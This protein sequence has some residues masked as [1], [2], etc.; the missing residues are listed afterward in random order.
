[1]SGGWSVVFGKQ[2]GMGYVEPGLAVVGQRLKVK[3]LRQEWDAVVVE[4]SPYD[5]GNAVIRV[6]G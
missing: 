1:T 2:I 5:P 6:D 3:I 4:D